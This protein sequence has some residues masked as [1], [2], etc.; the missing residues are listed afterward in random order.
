M[1]INLLIWSQSYMQTFT[2]TLYIG[3]QKPH[4]LVF[5][6]WQQFAVNRYKMRLIGHSNLMQLFNLS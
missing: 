5:V 3:T 4:F 2:S 6:T 1:R